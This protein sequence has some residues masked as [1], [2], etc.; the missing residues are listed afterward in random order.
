MDLPSARLAALL[1]AAL[2]LAACASTGEEKDPG[3]DKAAAEAGDGKKETPDADLAGKGKPALYHRI[4]SLTE[5]WLQAHSSSGEGASREAEALVSAIGREVWARFDEVV[6]D[7]KTSDNPRWRLAAARGLGFVHDLRVL[8][9]LQGA[10]GDKDSSVVAAALVSLARTPWA[11][12][13]DRKVAGLLTYPDK[14]V[15]G[16]AA[17]CLAHV[18]QTRRQQKLPILD[19][20]DRAKGIEADLLV[21]LFDGADPIVRGNA[22]Q[23]LGQLDSPT[24]EDALLNRVRDDHPFV[25]LKVAQ[26]LALT[27]TPKGYEVLLDSL[28][29]EQG[30]NV[31]IVTA[32]AIGAIAERQGLAPPY[33][34]LKTDAAAWRKWLKK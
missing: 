30:K 25:R 20:P 33:A 6:E 2:A 34:D 5:S 24:A 27:G 17:L 9:P 16:G 19:P 13:D 21:L 23:A 11:D 12:T 32:L 29:R 26:A 28:G 1:A 15:A 3:K 8:P 22:A 14:V 10:L 31:S 4:Q 7:L 18:F